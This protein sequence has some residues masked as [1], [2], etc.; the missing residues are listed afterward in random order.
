MHA[1]SIKPDSKQGASDEPSP[2]GTQGQDPRPL[3]GTQQQATCRSATLTKAETQT[4]AHYSPCAQRAASSRACP[5]P[6]AWH[7]DASL[8]PPGGWKVPTSAHARTHT[9]AHAHT[10]MCVH[11]NTHT[12]T[13][14]HTHTQSRC[15]MTSN[16][17]ATREQPCAGKGGR[18]STAH[19]CCCGTPPVS[20]RLPP[21]DPRDRA[22]RPA[23]HKE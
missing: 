19:A 12:H 20:G 23:Q 9:H 7:T 10:Y 8:S 15:F 13:R 22:I 18:H 17:G 5:P 2:Q 11:P 14:T 6:R 16:G 1:T 21:R 3:P 4:P